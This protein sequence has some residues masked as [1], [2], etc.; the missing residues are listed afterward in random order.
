MGKR[1]PESILRREIERMFNTT[2][3]TMS[4]LFGALREF[5]GDETERIVG[6]ATTAYATQ[7]ELASYKV[8][9]DIGVTAELVWQ[10]SDDEGV[11]PIC[12]ALNERVVE[13]DGPLPPHP[14]CAAEL[15]CRC[16]IFPR[17]EG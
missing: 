4:D 6:N 15:G 10:T 5:F 7:R 12:R 16:G 2:G 1:D 8:L 17:I 3:I 14:Q 13:T 9:L 11:C